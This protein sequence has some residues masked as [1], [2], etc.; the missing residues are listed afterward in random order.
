MCSQTFEPCCILNSVR[1]LKYIE[2]YCSDIS[3]SRVMVM[4]QSPA[5]LLSNGEPSDRCYCVFFIT[6]ALYTAIAVCVC[7]CVCV[8]V[9]RREAAIKLSECLSPLW[10]RGFLSAPL[11]SGSPPFTIT[12]SSVCLCVPVCPADFIC[13]S[14]WGSRPSSRSNI[15]Y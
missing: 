14:T 13:L 8:C 7:V 11:I 4:G 9:S 1:R 10:G 6:Q 2:I 3:C 5:A 15:M 12:S